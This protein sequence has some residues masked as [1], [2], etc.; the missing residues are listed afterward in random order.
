MNSPLPPAG[1]DPLTS[2]QLDVRQAAQ[3]QHLQH[4]VL[5]ALVRQLPL[6]DVLTLVCR[7]VERISPE[8]VASILAVREGRL[9]PL[10]APSLPCHYVD[11]L[12]GLPIGPSAG[13][14]GTAAW[15]GEPVEVADIAA[16]PLWEPYRALA[17]PLGLRACWSSPIK[18]GD[19]QVLGTFAFYYREPRG[20]A[21][22][23]RRLVELCV[24][25]CALAFER[26]QARAALHQ[27]ANYDS[28]TGLA[29]RAM[30]AAQAARLLTDLGRA[31]A[32]L[33]LVYLDLDRFELVNASQGHAAGDE[34]LR[35]VGRRIVAEVRGVDLVARLAADEFV[36][37]LPHCGGEQAAL[38]AQRLLAAISRP[39]LL[40]GLSLVPGAS[41]GIALF[42]E[43]GAEAETLL[44]H[45]DA[46][47]RQAKLD[48]PGR[49][50]FF[51][52]EMNQRNQ[53]RLTLEVALRGA[54]RAGALRLHYQ[55]Q[56]ACDA[57]HA[58]YGVEALARWTDP[59]LGEIPPMR[60]IP[61]AQE[62]GLMPELGRWVLNE[63][64]RQLADWQRRGIAVPRVA[65][66][67]SPTDFQDVDLPGHVADT[68]RRHGV[69]GTALTL[70][71][72]EGVMMDTGPE[73]LAT[74]H[75]LHAL[76]V[77]L[78]LD[79][80]GTGYSSLG[81]LHRLPIDELKLDRSF[82]HGVDAST[83]AQALV[84][85]VLRIGES[86]HL[87]VVAEGVETEAERAFLCER[88]CDIA[89]GYLFARPMP[90]VELEGW[91]AAWPV[92]RAV[93]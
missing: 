16:D 9:Q 83:A 80:F 32:P 40:G 14:C 34:L 30:L 28:L 84:N 78:S 35:E 36:V 51:R 58:A 20:P 44:R 69:P 17:L 89:Q 19:G 26:E 39:L 57:D 21:P 50:R 61:L 42:P 27:L 23:H 41:A 33:A 90:P 52:D 54:L 56:V 74:L 86:L 5:S 70:E 22:R 66:N 71:M 24:Q 13:S 46:A 76:G 3:E 68:L 8:V 55:P 31:G 85:T 2:Q 43:D 63:A 82:V 25:L 1:L 65:V 62:C 73:T 72:T 45:G 75:A 4:V 93:A 11:A 53:Q 6:V 49:M 29:N 59:V 15:R 81:Q 47:M 91:L 88:G 60:F 38:A 79:D 67:L 87:R 18:G 10:S 92:V 64:C 7:E 37:L 12:E 77:H 48:G